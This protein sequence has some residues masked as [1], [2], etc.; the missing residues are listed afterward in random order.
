MS[1]EDVSARSYA[2]GLLA[3]RDY[4]CYELTARL[5]VRGY[6]A[7]EAERVVSQ[8]ASENLVSDRRYGSERVRVRAAQGVGPFRILAE[9]QSKGL[10]PEIISAVLD[11]HDPMWE[12]RARRARAKR[13]GEA[14]PQGVTERARQSRFLQSR[15][16]TFEQI[17][18]AVST[19]RT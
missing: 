8:L 19:P 7:D 16:F 3:R 17:T 14:I 10:G 13:F 15:G 4:S 6:E 1:P 5:C 11:N 18:F 12:E 9:L 2:I